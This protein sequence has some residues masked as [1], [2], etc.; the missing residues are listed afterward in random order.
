MEEYSEGRG[1]EVRTT[2]YYS[3]LCVVSFLAP[4]AAEA[5]P[6]WVL[7]RVEE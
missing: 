7:H 2:G 4:R 1:L 5:S 3:E 6:K